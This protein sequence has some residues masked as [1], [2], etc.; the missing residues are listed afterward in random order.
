MRLFQLV[1]LFG[2]LFHIHLAV[3]EFS[4]QLAS[5]GVELFQFR[6]MLCL[7]LGSG[8]LKLDFLQAVIDRLQA[9][10][11]SRA[12]IEPLNRFHSS[13]L[14]V[15][16]FLQALCGSTVFADTAFQILKGVNAVCPEI[17]ESLVH[18]L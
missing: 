15:Q 5:G 8:L 3:R 10:E 11:S 17:I 14:F 16:R 6:F 1:I 7:V 9:L 2:Q 13:G 18:L 12:V 4:G